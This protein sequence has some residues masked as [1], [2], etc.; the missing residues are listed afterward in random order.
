MTIDEIRNGI[1]GEIAG[2]KSSGFPLEVFPKK[3][4]TLILD[5]V[6][7]ENY[8]PEYA[9]SALLTAAAVAIGNSRHLNIKGQWNI[10]PLFYMI[11]VGRP[12]AGK[13]PP[14]QFAFKPLAEID[15]ERS[16]IYKEEH[17]LWSEA[18]KRYELAQKNG[19][20]VGEPPV[21]PKQQRTVIT[22]F[23]YEAMVR[24][25]SDNPRGIVVKYDEIIGLFKSANRY[26]GSPIIEMLLSIFSNDYFYMSRCGMEDTLAIEHPCISIIG[27]TQT[28]LVP[29]I[30]DLGLLDNGFVDRFIFVYPLEVK[31]P[32][33]NFNQFNQI[34]YSPLESWRDIIRRLHSLECGVSENGD[35]IEP[36]IIGMT[37]HAR[38]L[39]YDWHNRNVDILNDISDDRLVNTRMAK[40]DYLAARFAL[41]L[42][43][44]H[45]AYG[46][47]DCNAVNQTSVLSAI[48]LTE[49]FEDSYRRL[50]N[51]FKGLGLNPVKQQ[52]LDDLSTVFTT[53]DAIRAGEEAGLA[54]RTVQ[55]TLTELSSMGVIMKLGRGKY[56]K[57]SK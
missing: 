40:W 9:A 26:N 11:L 37:D 14:L 39:F 19:D 54:K 46:E 22:D 34:D 4:Q 28:K 55:Y 21:E 8:V 33:W 43:L 5:L 35:R 42:Q 38:S 15:R 36:V 41:V 2:V 25:H 10:A 24:M 57:I 18:Q 50:E 29:K 13:T 53:E 20:N 47:L 27:T 49:Y 51:A 45:W 6:R 1:N 12:G 3:M 7:K 30:F 16:N 31:I 23:T 44:L 52:M 32:I 17:R 48:K 56:Q